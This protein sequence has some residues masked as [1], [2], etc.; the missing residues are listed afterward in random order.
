MDLLANRASLFFAKPLL[1]PI[2]REIPATVTAKSH[3]FPP[4]CSQ[5]TPEELKYILELSINS[6]SLGKFSAQAEKKPDFVSTGS[7]LLR[8]IG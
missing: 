5:Q 2:S 6:V 8:Y 3:G 1:P 7:P 4:N